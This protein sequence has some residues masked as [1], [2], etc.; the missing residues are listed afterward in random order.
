MNPDFRDL[1]CALSD[2]EARFLVAGAYAVTFHGSP[3][4][5]GDLDIWIEPTEANA[6]RVWAALERFGAPMHDL[7]LEDLRSEDRELQIGVPPRR[8]DILTSLTGIEF[9]GA[10]TRRVA[11]TLEGVTCAFIGRADLIDNKRAVG[12]LRDLA[13][14]ER[15]EGP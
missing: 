11:T 15:L 7:R 1:L 2:A 6:R 9:E 14:L 8:V 5:T 4:S 3:R 13:D 10:W 12:R